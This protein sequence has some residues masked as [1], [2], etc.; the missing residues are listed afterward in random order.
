MLGL[1]IILLVAC[2]AAAF[3]EQRVAV[4]GLFA[5][6]AL[7]AGLLFFLQVKK[8]LSQPSALFHSSLAELDADLARLRG[9]LRDRQ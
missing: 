9:S 8:Q 1:G 5:L 2:V 7:L 4:F 3:W 6:L